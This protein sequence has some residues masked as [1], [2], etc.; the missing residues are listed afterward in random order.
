MLE[1][2]TTELAELTAEIVASYVA[3]NSVRPGD[4]PA[5]I[6]SIY[7]ML[8][9]L[10]QT[11]S[12]APTAE[13]KPAVPIKKSVTDDFIISLED[14]RRFKSLKRHL[15]AEYGMTPEPVSRQVGPPGRLPD[16]RPSLCEAAFRVGKVAGSWTKGGCSRTGDRRATAAPE[17]DTPVQDRRTGLDLQFMKTS[18]IC[19]VGPA[20]IR[21]D[22]VPRARTHGSAGDER[23]CSTSPPSMMIRRDEAKSCYERR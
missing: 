17:E 1:A 9:S 12:R 4:L 20:A 22:R 21:S 3:N 11:E 18:L 19:L 13:L 5:L 15:T 7:R 14:G 2:Q 23:P 16:G 6:T 8:G 10:G